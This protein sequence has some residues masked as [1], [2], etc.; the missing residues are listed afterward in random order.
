VILEVINEILRRVEEK[1][2]GP[3]R[4]GFMRLEKYDVELFL[5]LVRQ[6]T[7]L[8]DIFLSVTE[9]IQSSIPPDPKQRHM[10]VDIF[11]STKGSKGFTFVFIP[12]RLRPLR[13]LCKSL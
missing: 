8:E 4:N 3:R 13:S 7:E 9:L 11:L 5:K 12:R 1:L 10:D 6:S 2:G